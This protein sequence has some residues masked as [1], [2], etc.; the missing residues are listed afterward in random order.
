MKLRVAFDLDETLGV[1]V[2]QNNEITGF[3]ARTGCVE[4][5][6]KLSCEFTLCLWSV[7]NRGYVEKVLAFGLKQFFKEIYSWDEVPWTWKDV[8]KLNMDYLI[9]DSPSYWEEAKKHGIENRYIVVSA[10]GSPDDM[11]DPL[12]WVRTVEEVLL[13]DFTRTIG[14]A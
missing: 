4:L 11:K 14:K 6:E 8:R 7:S 5:L 9:D 2:I 12:M 13:K 1:P 3:Q 10:Y